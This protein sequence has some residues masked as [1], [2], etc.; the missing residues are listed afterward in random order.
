[1]LRT[2]KD[3]AQWLT[4]E[5]RY[6]YPSE[7]LTNLISLGVPVELKSLHD[8]SLASKARNAMDASSTSFDN[9]TAFKQTRLSDGSLVVSSRIGRL[10]NNIFARL[11]DPSRDR[12]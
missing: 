11:Q 6:A 4:N 3:M 12:S 7:L 9:L 2:C 8:I 10:F 1:M 5:P